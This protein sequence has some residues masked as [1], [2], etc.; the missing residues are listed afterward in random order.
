M[1]FVTPYIAQLRRTTRGL[2]YFGFFAVNAVF[3]SDRCERDKAG[4]LPVLSHLDFTL[5]TPYGPRGGSLAVRFQF[6]AMF[7][8]A[9][10]GAHMI[11]L[12]GRSNRLLTDGKE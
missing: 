10:G 11:P 2:C 5:G 7:A 12:P 3:Y 4:H 8:D 9:A 6:M 1:F